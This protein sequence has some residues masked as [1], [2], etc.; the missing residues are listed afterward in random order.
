MG[1]PHWPTAWRLSSLG[2]I[3]LAAKWPIRRNSSAGKSHRFCTTQPEKDF[4]MSATSETKEGQQATAPTTESKGG[5]TEL[6][7]N[8]QGI[9]AT[10]EKLNE[11]LDGL[12]NKLEEA[13]KPRRG[14]FTGRFTKGIRN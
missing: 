13:T 11:R 4:R 10:I 6:L 7:K 2:W 12:D 3:R 9:P 8:L 5:A 14:E 1:W